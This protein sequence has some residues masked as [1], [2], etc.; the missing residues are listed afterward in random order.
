MATRYICTYFNVNYL[1]RGLALIDSILVHNPDSV[2]YVLALDEKVESS[3]KLNV[4][5]VRLITLDYYLER[6]EIKKSKYSDEKQFLFSLTPNLCKLIIFENEDIDILLYLDADV[7]VRSSLD[8]IYEEFSSFSIGACSH[9]INSLIKRFSHNYG[10]YNVGVNLFRNDESGRKCLTEWSRECNEWYPN[11]PGYKLSF[12]SDQ[13]FLDSWP[14][15]YKDRF[16]ELKNLGVNLAPWNAI[17]FRYKWDN[18]NLY[19]N[20]NKLI[21]YH[22]SSLVQESESV[23]NANGGYAVFRLNKHLR[24]LY[25]EYINHVTSFDLDTEKVVKLSIRG[26]FKKRIFFK[27]F[28]FI[29]KSKIE[30]SKC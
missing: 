15:R 6:N 24:S 30:V 13:I 28:G 19:V 14:K 16:I 25:I 18:K 20:G 11:M 8:L 9:R 7:Y 29:F 21:I 26:S 23:W 3:L 1:A 27:L 10:N 4:N 5:N 17:Y 22:F 12:F 2:I